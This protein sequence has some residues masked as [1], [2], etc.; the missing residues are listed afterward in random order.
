MTECLYFPAA[1]A[2]NTKTTMRR[3]QGRPME[4]PTLLRQFIDIACAPIYANAAGNPLQALGHGIGKREGLSLADWP[5]GEGL[6]RSQCGQLSPE[7][8]SPAPDA[9]V[10]ISLTPQ[11]MPNTGYLYPLPE[12]YSGLIVSAE[13]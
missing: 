12:Q 8:G 6:P 10:G 3:I 9:P 5:F 13:S 2:Y 7:P 1:L 4:V 11:D